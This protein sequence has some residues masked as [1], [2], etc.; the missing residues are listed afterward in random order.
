MRAR[1]LLVAHCVVLCSAAVPA[2][3]AEIAGV[4]I[5]DKARVGGSELVLNGV[6]LRTR[7]FFKVY[8]AGLYLSEKKTSA[9]EAIAA[10]GPKRVSM[11]LLREITAQ[12]LS[13]ALE[14]GMRDNTPAAEL[15]KLKP[16][17]AKLTEIMTSIGA[18]KTGM[19]VALDFL[20]GSG[21]RVLVN[22]APRG[23][24]I[25][26]EDFYRALLR[27]W[28]GESPADRSLKNGLLGQK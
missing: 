10:P 5:D 23:D 9:A 28:L 18:A 1:R 17:I 12:Q 24:S 15:E 16:R 21:T 6:G 14:E 7:A 4:N 25:E 27:I 19:T 2:G 3:A 8:A 13:D 11:T 22:G 20:P 26:G